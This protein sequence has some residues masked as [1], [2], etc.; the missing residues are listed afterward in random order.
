MFV[1][2]LMKEREKSVDLRVWGSSENL[3]G[4]EGGETIIEIH[5]TKIFH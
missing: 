4:V 5:C 1:H 2:I 3:G